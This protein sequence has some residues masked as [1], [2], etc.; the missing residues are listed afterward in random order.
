VRSTGTTTIL[1]R[2]K[3]EGFLKSFTT[4]DSFYSRFQIVHVVPEIHT[5]HGS[6]SLLLWNAAK[7]GKGTRSG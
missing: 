6:L 2:G 4:F 3:D 1:R 5:F 7:A